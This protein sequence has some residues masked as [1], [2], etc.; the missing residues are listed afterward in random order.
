MKKMFTA[1]MAL[2]MIVSSC[3]DSSGEANSEKDQGKGPITVCD[4]IDIQIDMMKAMLNGMSEDDAG[5]KYAE[6]MESCKKMGEGKS[7]EE[8]DA[9][10]KQAQDC[11]SMGEMQKISQ[12]LMTKM[13]SEQMMEQ[14]VDALEEGMDDI[15]E[16]E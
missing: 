16:A 4:C 1:V 13:M 8:L 10:N 3:G 15:G 9:M 5:A 6:E 14:G 11:E 2:G 12:E 7:P